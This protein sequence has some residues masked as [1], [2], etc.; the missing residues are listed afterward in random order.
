[1]GGN[2]LD[3]KEGIDKINDPSEIAAGIQTNVK[4]NVVL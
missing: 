2:R 3:K 1:M 4:T